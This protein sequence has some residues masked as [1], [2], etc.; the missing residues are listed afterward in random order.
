M[1]VTNSEI[2]TKK[3][4]ID[5]GYIVVSQHATT[6]V[7]T[8]VDGVVYRTQVEAQAALEAETP[9]ATT[10]YLIL[11]VDPLAGILMTVA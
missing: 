1:S 11:R 4:M 3:T 5:A 9:M 7:L 8:L 2:V 10:I 6:R